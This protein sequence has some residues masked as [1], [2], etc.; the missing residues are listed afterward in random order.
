MK[1]MELASNSPIQLIFIMSV[2]PLRETTT[3]GSGSPRYGVPD[4]PLDQSVVSARLHSYLQTTGVPSLFF[5][6]LSHG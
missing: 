6:S 4:A 2:T 1:P 5:L 3:S